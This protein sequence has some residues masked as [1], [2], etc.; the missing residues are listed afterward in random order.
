MW[1]TK[2]MSQLDAVLTG[3]PLTL[4]LNVEAQ[5]VSREWETPMS[6]NEIDGNQLDA[7]VWNTKEMSQLD[8][9]LTGVLLNLTFDLE[10][11]K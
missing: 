8:A 11:W 10:C 7:L 5:I 9:V 4:T 1:N 3:E 6:W 2:K